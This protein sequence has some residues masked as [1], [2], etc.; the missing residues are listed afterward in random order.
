MDILLSKANILKESKYYE[1]SIRLRICSHGN[2]KDV[3][4]LRKALA[5]YRDIDLKKIYSDN[6]EIAW[7]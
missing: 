4:G 7:R 1:E 2:R 3:D 5:K 6:G